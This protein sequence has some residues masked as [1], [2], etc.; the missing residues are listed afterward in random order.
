MNPVDCV[1][2]PDRTNPE[3]QAFINAF[4]LCERQQPALETKRFYLP[5]GEANITCC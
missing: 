2:N 1:S 4:A 3:F 5:G